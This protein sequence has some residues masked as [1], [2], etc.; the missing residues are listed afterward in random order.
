MRLMEATVCRWC[1]LVIA[2]FPSC[3]SWFIRPARFVEG[4]VVPT[5]FNVTS[6]FLACVMSSSANE[7]GESRGGKGREKGEVVE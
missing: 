3:R 6:P 7:G 4:N 5:K 1:Q 2:S